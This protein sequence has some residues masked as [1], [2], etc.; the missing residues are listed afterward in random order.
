MPFQRPRQ[1]VLRHDGH[2]L[3]GFLDV[4]LTKA[5]LPGLGRLAHRL[6]AEG[7]GDRQQRHAARSAARALTGV[8]Y[9]LVHAMEIV[10][11]RRHNVCGSISFDRSD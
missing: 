10:G 5:A 7:L 9:L 11:N 1:A 6:G 3:H 8:G 4:V 2:F